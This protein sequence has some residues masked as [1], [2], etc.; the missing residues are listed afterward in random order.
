MNI[1]PLSDRVVLKWVEKESITKSGIYLPE[2]ANAER[3]YIYEVVAIWPGKKDIDMWAI[4]IG[5]RVLCG[6]YAGDEIKLDDSM[7]KIV[8]IDYILW[9]VK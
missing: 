5:D 3:P 9:I 1:K 8:A 2:S 6:Q 7:Y 4:A